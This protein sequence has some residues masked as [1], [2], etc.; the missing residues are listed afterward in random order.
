MYRSL[1]YMRLTKHTSKMWRRA[2]TC[3][4]CCSLLFTCHQMKGVFCWNKRSY[5]KQ[6]HPWNWHHLDDSCNFCSTTCMYRW[7]LTVSWRMWHWAWHSEL[8]SSQMLAL[9][10]V[11]IWMI[12]FLFSL[13]DTTSMIYKNNYKCGLKRAQCTLCQSVCPDESMSR[14]VSSFSGYCWYMALAPTPWSCQ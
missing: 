10:L 7:A 13:K 2:I 12:L 6:R 9:G 3:L 1:L 4:H 11:T 5:F 8:M 14:E